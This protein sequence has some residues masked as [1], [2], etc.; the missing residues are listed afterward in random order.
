MALRCR[1][2]MRVLILVLGILG[3][4]SFSIECSCMVPLTP[5]SAQNPHP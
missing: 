2:F 3:L 5:V 4:V 1:L